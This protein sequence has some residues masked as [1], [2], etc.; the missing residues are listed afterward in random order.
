MTV[1]SPS[2]KEETSEKVRVV[3]CDDDSDSDSYN[4]L[5]Q[6]PKSVFAIGKGKHSFLEA[7]S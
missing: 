5:W 3:C 2:V 1:C 4:N 6:C 7:A